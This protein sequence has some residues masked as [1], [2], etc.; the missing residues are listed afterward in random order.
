MS[1]DR[2]LLEAVH[3]A[4]NIPYPATIGDR[5]VYARILAERVMHARI[6][7]EGVLTRG[8]NADW[9][10]GWLL[11]QLA[12]HPATGYRRFGAGR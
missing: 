3:E 6:A 9:S 12:L 8:D 11:G 5:E 4:L 10:A 1:G 2:R 7:L